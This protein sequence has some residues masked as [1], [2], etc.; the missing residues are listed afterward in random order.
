VP[1]THSAVESRVSS[2]ESERLAA[3]MRAERAEAA[4]TAAQN[5]LLDVTKRCAAHVQMFPAC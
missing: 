2:K 4:A 5:E 3:V 1:V